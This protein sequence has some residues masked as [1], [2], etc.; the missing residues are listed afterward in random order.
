MKNIKTASSRVQG[1]KT[2]GRVINHLS[3]N[4]F[5]YIPDNKE[6]FSFFTFHFSFDEA[7]FFITLPSAARFRL[8]SLGSA[9][10]GR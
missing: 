3:S 7:P 5:S 6:N 8:T 1:G 2:G 4:T 10:K 9:I